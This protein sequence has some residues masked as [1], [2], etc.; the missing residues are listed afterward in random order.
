MTEVDKLKADLDMFI[1]MPN[2]PML[3]P[4]IKASAELMERWYALW[5]DKDWG[6]GLDAIEDVHQLCVR[7]IAMLRAVMKE[8]EV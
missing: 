3:I 6:S 8:E 2:D 4:D 1:A 5:S 7:C